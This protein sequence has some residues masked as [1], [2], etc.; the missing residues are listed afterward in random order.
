MA[1][2]YDIVESKI[3]SV[4]SLCTEGEMR[5]RVKV[6]PDG[7][8]IRVIS[9][10]GPEKRPPPYETNKPGVPPGANPPG[11]KIGRRNDKS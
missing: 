6:L 4:Y 2:A 9:G 3:S 10:T 11:L 7:T 1:P 5:V 8:R